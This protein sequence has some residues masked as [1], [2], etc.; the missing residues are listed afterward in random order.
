MNK[1]IFAF[2]VFC[3]L[4]ASSAMAVTVDCDGPGWFNTDVC[5]DHELQDEFDEVTGEIDDLDNVIN[6][7]KEKWEKDLV[8]G[9]GMSSTGMWRHITGDGRL[10]RVYETVIDYLHTIFATKAEVEATNDRIDLIECRM[11]HGMDYTNEELRF[12]QAL[13]KSKR[14]DQP[15]GLGPW[16]CDYRTDNC[17]QV[18]PQ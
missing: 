11:I 10:E 5:Q 8:G 1:T 16:T 15:V 17:I 4:L 18:I 7:N 6:T 12:C 14:L 2:T 9:G 13:M 3:V